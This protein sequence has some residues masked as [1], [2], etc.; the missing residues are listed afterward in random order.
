MA[1]EIF[2]DTG[3]WIALTDKGDQMHKVAS[4]ALPAI[5]KRWPALITTNLVIA[6][7]YNLIR[8]RLGHSQGIQFLESLAA[9]PM[10]LKIYS[11]GIAEG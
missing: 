1:R 3:A 5:L 4:Q 8:R 10:L 7:A 2:V 6:E 9:T 11:D